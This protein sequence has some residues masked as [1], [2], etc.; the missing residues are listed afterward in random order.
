[1]SPIN[2]QF[3]THNLPDSHFCGGSLLND[4]WI[5][6]AA[7]CFLEDDGEIESYYYRGSKVGFQFD[8]L[9]SPI[10]QPQLVEPSSKIPKSKFENFSKASLQTI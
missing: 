8:V 4:R 1:M 10:V 2:F 9:T 7:H 3:Q 5:L 6:T